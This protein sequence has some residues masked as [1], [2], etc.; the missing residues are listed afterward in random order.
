VGLLPSLYGLRQE[1]DNLILLTALRFQ[2]EY[3]DYAVILVTNDR[4]LRCK[5]RA[6]N[7]QVQERR[8]ERAEDT[9]TFVSKSKK[10]K[11]KAKACYSKR[12]NKHGKS[13]RKMNKQKKRNKRRTKSK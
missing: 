13:K 6:F 10:P 9:P 3:S 7:L 4:L 1:V 8:I 5:A 11:G 12:K 2:R